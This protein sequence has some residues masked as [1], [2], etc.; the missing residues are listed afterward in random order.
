MTTTIDEVERL[1]HVMR[2]Q[3]AAEAEARLAEVQMQRQAEAATK[4]AEDAK[5][6]AAWWSSEKQ[7]R[8]RVV[9][10]PGITASHLD[11]RGDGHRWVDHH[12]AMHRG[13]ELVPVEIEGNERVLYLHS[14]GDF[15]RLSCNGQTGTLWRQANPR[16]TEQMLAALPKNPQQIAEPYQER[17]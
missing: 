6:R 13:A 7:T 1:L 12:G 11:I 14:L 17:A 8:V 9:V 4:D 16:L 5:A 10:P 3:E 2:A 15:K